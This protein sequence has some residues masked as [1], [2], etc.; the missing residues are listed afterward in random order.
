MWMGS[1]VTHVCMRL[2]S[3]CR[4]LSIEE[5]YPPALWPEGWAVINSST[6]LSS[7]LCWWQLHTA[8][9]TPAKLPRDSPA[10]LISISC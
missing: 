2:I 5:T 1:G 4:N 3:I 8:K 10:V 7:V 6:R 9:G